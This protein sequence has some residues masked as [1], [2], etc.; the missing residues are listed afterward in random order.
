LSE[1]PAFIP[2]LPAL[3]SYPAVVRPLLCGLWGLR[4]VIDVAALLLLAYMAVAI[5]VQIIGRYVFNYSIAWSEESATFAQVWLTLLGAGIA[6]RTNAHVGVDVLIRKAPVPVQKV[7]EAG[8]LALGI[9]FMLAVVVGSLALVSIGMRI[10]SPALNIPMAVPYMSLPVGFA[11]F[12]LEFV[13]SG[14]T[15]LLSREAVQ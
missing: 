7:F 9:W 8:S 1:R 15:R 13:I 10:D 11:Y 2:P 6:M 12:L 4:R 3:G 14:V 5:L